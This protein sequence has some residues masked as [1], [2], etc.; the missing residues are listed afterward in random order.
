M[1]VVTRC[2]NTFLYASCT[3]ESHT[4]SRIIS[5]VSA[6]ATLSRQDVTEYVVHPTW[7]RVRYHTTRWCLGVILHWHAI[8]C[9]RA[10]EALQYYDPISEHLVSLIQ[11]FLFNFLSLSCSLGTPHDADNDIVRNLISSKAWS[12]LCRSLSFPVSILPKEDWN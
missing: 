9:N 8:S 7:H 6:P 3:W 4:G 2:D 11:N 5:R 1:K 12:W 10:D